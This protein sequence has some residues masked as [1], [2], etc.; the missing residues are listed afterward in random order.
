M[1]NYYKQYIIHVLVILHVF[2]IYTNNYELSRFITLHRIPRNTFGFIYKE[3]RCLSAKK[4][5]YYEQYGTLETALMSYYIHN[6]Y[7]LSFIIYFELLRMHV[8]I[9]W[10]ITFQ[11]NS[12]LYNPLDTRLLSSAKPQQRLVRMRGC[13][14]VPQKQTRT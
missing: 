2:F 13:I 12:I 6:K 1:F 5:V 7:A 8:W 14:W 10:L 3:F 11:C 4:N 9:V